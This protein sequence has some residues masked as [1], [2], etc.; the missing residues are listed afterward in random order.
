LFSGKK[1][2]DLLEHLASARGSMI[3]TAIAPKNV[4]KETAGLSEE[5]QA[6]IKEAIRNA[7]TLEEVT[8]LEKLL[9]AGRIPGQNKK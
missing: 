2:K 6:K 4:S 9:K 3:N 1:G 5:E 8:R 7:K